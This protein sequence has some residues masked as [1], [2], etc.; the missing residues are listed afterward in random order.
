MPVFAVEIETRDT[1]TYYVEAT[2]ADDAWDAA[3]RYAYNMH[4]DADVQR[5][6][7]I[8]PRIRPDFVVLPSI[9]RAYK[10][11]KEEIAMT[12]AGIEIMFKREITR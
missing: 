4:D 7:E 8:D 9:E 2:N 1:T 12:F 11:A 3:E 10:R 5:V 6:D